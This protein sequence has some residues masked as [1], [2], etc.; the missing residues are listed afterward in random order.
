S[1]LNAHNLRV[2]P[3]NNQRQNQR[4]ALTLYNGIVYVTSAS[5]GDTG[6]YHGWILGYNATTLQL[7]KKYNSTRNGGLGGFWMS[8]QG[9][10]IDT[11]TGFLYAITGNGS[12]SQT[13]SMN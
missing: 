3:Y 5:H 2:V 1:I 7:V 8:G 4:S 10:A 6:P 9:V 12:F 11:A 13:V